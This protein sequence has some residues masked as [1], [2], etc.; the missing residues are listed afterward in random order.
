MHV[1]TVDAC[2]RPDPY[3][4]T[5]SPYTL[6]IWEQVIRAAV[7]MGPIL[8]LQHGVRMVGNPTC[9]GATAVEAGPQCAN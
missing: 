9:G 8:C 7:R 3:R 2:G 1:L 5:T 6:T 4:T